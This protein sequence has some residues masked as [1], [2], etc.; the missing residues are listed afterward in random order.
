MKKTLTIIFL[1][2]SI[3]ALSGCAT[4]SRGKSARTLAGL[5]SYEI[6][7]RKYVSVKEFCQKANIDWNWDIISKRVTL[8]GNDVQVR[9]YVGSYFALVNNQPLVLDDRVRIYQGK[10][11]MPYSFAL[12]TF[13]SMLRRKS[14]AGSVK[15]DTR[16]RIKRIVIDAG[17]GGR[18]P[19]A[20]GRN[21]LKEKDVVLDI[22]RRLKRELNGNGIDIILTRNSDRFVS[23]WKR[24]HIANTKEADLFISVHA[25]GSYARQAHGFEM[26]YLSEA[27]D[28]NARALAAAE[29]A[30]LYFEDYP[31]SDLRDTSTDL[32]ATLWDIKNTEDRA[33]SIG[34]AEYISS[35]M[36]KGLRGRNRGVKSARFY[37]LKYVRMPSVLVEVGFIT[38]RNEERQ[39]ADRRHRQRVAKA[40]AK[41]ILSYKKEYEKTDGFTN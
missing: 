18:E 38:N 9:L 17:H 7:H 39:L 36:A 25:N 34:L 8:K 37:V 3:V 11:V 27:T 12:R 20:R 10:V 2:A 15:R 28:D 41:G 14:F 4:V 13:S 5:R 40:I 16:Y 31:L 33:E 29:N 30:S 6:E 22:A 26:W 1:F 24:A 19:G 35:A 32:K 21:G 23:L